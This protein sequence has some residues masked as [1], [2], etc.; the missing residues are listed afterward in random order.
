MAGIL[1]EIKAQLDR[2]EVRLAKCEAPL[3][4]SMVD[5]Q[6]SPLTRRKHCEAVRA[7]VA[8]GDPRAY[9]RGKR[10]LMTGDALRE[11]MLA[12]MQRVAGKPANTT[13]DDAFYRN[14]L[15]EVGG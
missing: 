2:I 6:H 15:E 5:Q 1:E 13:E 10:C 14:L 7:L 9:I 3:A 12:D 4:S 8:K 11:V